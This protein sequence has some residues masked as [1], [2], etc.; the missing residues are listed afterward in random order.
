[1]N[2]PQYFQSKLYLLMLCTINHCT[3]YGRVSVGHQLSLVQRDSTCTICEIWAYNEYELLNVSFVRKKYVM[4]TQHTHSELSGTCVFVQRE[5]VCIDLCVYV[6]ILFVN[7]GF[8][9]FL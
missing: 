5:K 1:M 7:T 2:G 8:V 9:V 3:T 6:L 4:R